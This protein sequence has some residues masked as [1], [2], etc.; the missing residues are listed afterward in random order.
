MKLGFIGFGEVGYE[1]SS[2]LVEQGLK[3]IYAYD[4]MQNHPE[5]GHIVKDKAEKAG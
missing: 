5:K 1:I 3:E 4:V 2:G